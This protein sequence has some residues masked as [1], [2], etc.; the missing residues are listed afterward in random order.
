MIPQMTD[1]LTMPFPF[2]AEVPKRERPAIM[3]GWA[4]LEEF[5][6]MVRQNG[7]AIPAT[8]AAKLLNVSK[9]RVYELIETGRL[10][11]IELGGH[12]FVTADSLVAW[13]KAEHKVGRPAGIFNGKKL[14][15]GVA[16][17]KASYAYGQEVTAS[18]P[19][20]PKNS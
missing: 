12:G 6:E 7:A 19:G 1:T 9:Q 18:R 13:G 4:E 20:R 5:Q 3:D 2:L 10:Q 11:R 15:D 14:H 16:L 17:A 8:F